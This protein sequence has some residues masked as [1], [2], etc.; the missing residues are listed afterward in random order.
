MLHSRAKI[1]KIANICALTGEVRRAATKQT[2]NKHKKT[3][4]KKN[5]KRAVFNKKHNK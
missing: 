2:Q 4:N 3:N 1:A 5:G